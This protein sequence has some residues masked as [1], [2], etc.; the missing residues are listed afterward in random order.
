MADGLPERIASKAIFVV[1]CPDTGA[2]R[3]SKRQRTLRVDFD[4]ILGALSCAVN[5]QIF[6]YG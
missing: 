3:L 4:E 6:G 2:K 1:R 5:N